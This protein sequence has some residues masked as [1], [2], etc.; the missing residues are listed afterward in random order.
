M[1]RGRPADTISAHEGNLIES[2][3]GTLK[4][5][6]RCSARRAEGLAAGG[7]A[8]ATTPLSFEP[9]EAVSHDVALAELAM[10]RALWIGAETVFDG[11]AAH[12]PSPG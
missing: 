8:I 3:P 9:D 4:S 6:V 2:L 1:P 7:T 5:V 12:W 10:A 11:L